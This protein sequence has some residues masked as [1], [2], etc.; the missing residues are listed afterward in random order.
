MTLLFP[1][2]QPEIPCRQTMWKLPGDIKEQIQSERLRVTLAANAAMVLLYWDIGKVIPDRQKKEGWGAK[3]IDYFSHDLKNAFP[4]MT[5]LSPRNLKYMRTF[6]ESWPDRGLVQRTVALIPWH[7]NIAHPDKLKDPEICIWYAHKTI[8]LLLCRSRNG[9]VVE[10]TYTLRGFKNPMGVAEWE[11]KLTKS[12][13]K[14]LKGSLP[15][16]EE[17]EA[18]TGGCRVSQ[19]TRHVCRSIRMKTNIPVVSLS[20][21]KWMFF[22][23]HL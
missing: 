23:I 7:S 10:Y 21:K 19:R 20:K 14:E 6:S 1:P 5:G 18:E 4:D 9:L 22:G 15:T 16:I 13:P 12:L 17:F 3:V 8:G 11:T 2:L